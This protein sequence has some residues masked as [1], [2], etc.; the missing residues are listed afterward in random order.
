MKLP[1]TTIQEW[2]SYDPE[3]GAVSWK[4]TPNRRIRIGQSAGHKWRDHTRPTTYIQIGFRYHDI[5][6]HIVAFAL[7]TGRLPVKTLD[8]IDGDGCNNRWRNLR[9]A[10]VLLNN[11]N[12]RLHRNNT[13]GTM[14]VDFQP[15]QKNKKWRACI[16]HRH[17]GFFTTR[18]EAVAARKQAEQQL[19]FHPNHGR[20]S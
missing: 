9:E 1:L 6:A 4:K 16:A 20:Q 17:I 8:H 5:P 19:G 10:G 12:R 13:S 14:G 15:R 18:E 3:T 7:M 11:Q 2:F